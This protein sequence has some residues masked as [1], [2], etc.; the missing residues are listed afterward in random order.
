M[1]AEAERQFCGFFLARL[2]QEATRFKE[3]TFPGH[4][5]GPQKWLNFVSG[6]IDTATGY[7]KL[8]DKKGIPSADRKKLIKGA[9]KLANW[10]YEAL[11]HLAGSDATQIPHEIV[12]PFQR[13]VDSLKIRNTIF[14]RAAHLPNYE[15]AWFDLRHLRTDL[16][17]PSRSLISALDKINW[18]V[19]RVTVPSQALGMLPH[20]AVV[21]HEL[22]HAVQERIRVDFSSFDQEL[23]GCQERIRNRLGSF[24]S[25]E[26]LLLAEILGNWINEL[27]ADAVG[28]YLSGPA[29]YFALCGYLELAGQTVGISPTHPPSDLRRRLLV[30][31][32]S[33]GSPSFLTVFEQKTGLRIT[34]TVN[35]AHVPTC[36]TGDAL[37]IE[38]GRHYEPAVA[39]I[40][41]E[42]VRYLETIAPSIFREAESYIRLSVPEL[43]YSP[44]A[45]DFDLTTHLE[46]IAE[47]VP[48]IEYRTSGRICA[49]GL[50]SILNVGW[51]AL[52]TGL[53]QM[54]IPKN[55]LGD[56][57]S[58]KMEQ[59][60]ELLLRAVE[61][62]EARRL[63]DEHK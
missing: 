1:T 49:V 47:L 55:S 26:Q 20:Y 59:L 6:L 56:P 10:A 60:H 14:F 39:A 13:W 53:R 37:F 25:N 57:I 24:G 22:G 12:A 27:K 48:P 38:L 35:S 29:F 44:T 40:C 30:E 11:G 52:L 41:A 28:H 62:S 15:L 7:L 21:G 51:A 5:T 16:D 63:W 33:V 36:P 45:L 2:A 8:A 3:T 61:L 31:Q 42:L 50:A 4:S 23:R 32:L 43:L 34:P 9:E 17:S 46:L 19:L 54:K 18:P 58:S